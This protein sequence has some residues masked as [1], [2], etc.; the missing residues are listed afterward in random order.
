MNSEANSEMSGVAAAKPASPTPPH[1]IYRYRFAVLAVILAT[2]L[3]TDQASKLW[4]RDSLARPLQGIGSDGFQHYRMSRQVVVVS[5]LFNFIYVE[6]PTSAFS[7]TKPIPAKYRRPMLIG[8]TYL[9]MALLLGWLI[10][11][12][13][14]DVI[15]VLGF[16]FVL[17]GAGGNLI[18]RQ[19]H[20]YVIDFIDWRLT[21]F[22]PGLPPWPTFNIADSSIVCGAL[23]IV[24]RSFFPY[25]DKASEAVASAPDSTTQKS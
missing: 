10:R 3:S 19:M 13:E 24:F 22:F 4:A 25:S 2:V 16:S 5:G 20:G 6:N 14:P 17:A 12:K 7:L 23:S 18:D 9:A 11:L 15:L 8:V 1:W 21:R